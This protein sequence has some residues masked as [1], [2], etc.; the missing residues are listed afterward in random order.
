MRRREVAAAEAV[1]P[2]VTTDT[3]VVFALAVLLELA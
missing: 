2:T 1:V 3:T